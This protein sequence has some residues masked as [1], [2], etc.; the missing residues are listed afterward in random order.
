MDIREKYQYSKCFK[1]FQGR[2]IPLKCVSCERIVVIK[3]L[4]CDK[5]LKMSYEIKFKIYEEY[6]RFYEVS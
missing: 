2:F 4:Y 5:I 6:L 1:W 3:K